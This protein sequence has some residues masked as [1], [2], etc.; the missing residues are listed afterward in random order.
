M[1]AFSLN[2][3]L[4]IFR[5][6]LNAG[7]D[8]I[9]GSTVSLFHVIVAIEVAFAGIYLAIGGQANLIEVCK[10]I[11]KVG[12]LFWLISNYATILDWIYTGFL[13]AG[14]EIGRGSGGGISVASL[15]NPDAI[16]ARSS[17]II[18]RFWQFAGTSM[19]TDS[20]GLPTLSTLLIAVTILPACICICLMAINVFI[21]Y[22][23]YL[24]LSSVALIFI[25]LALFRP[26]AWLF[27]RAQGAIFSLGIK[28]MVL[29][30]IV[31]ISDTIFTTNAMS[32]SFTSPVAPGEISEEAIV[33][34]FTLNN[35]FQL[36]IM[37]ITLLVLS[38]HAPSM[39]LG[40]LGGSPQLTAGSIASAIAGSRAGASTLGSTL[41]SV[42]R[43]SQTVAGAPV[44]LAARIGA[45]FRGGIKA[46]NSF[47]SSGSGDGSGSTVSGASQLLEKGMSGAYGAL[48]ATAGSLARTLYGGVADNVKE[49]VSRHGAS[50]E[51]QG[52]RGVQNIQQ[53]SEKI[54]KAFA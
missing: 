35:S 26:F 53:V 40:L 13:F 8:N 6:V 33:A 23:E 7:R 32:L 47:A 28:A 1:D 48:S 9:L 15:Q 20:F 14:S 52:Y 17:N 5:S 25:P 51:A 21:T 41:G 42:G 24:L 18:Q 44:A 31:A 34:L 46:V 43:G 49:C 36:L 54:K 39:A 29:G 16:L 12:T 3:Y 27:D 2:N 10:K 30:L 11:L 45:G 50:A 37:S 22:L 19:A 4:N 38:Y